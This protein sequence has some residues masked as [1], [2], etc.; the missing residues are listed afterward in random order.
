MAKGICRLCLSPYRS[1]IVKLVNQG[2]VFKRI[3]DKYAPLMNYTFGDR[4][5]YMMTRRH[6]KDQHKEE[7]LIVPQTDNKVSPATIENFAQRM[8][9]LGMQKIEDV[10]PDTIAL[11]DV[12]SAQKLLLDSKKL[13]L[14]ENAMD[15]MLGKL[16]APP[17]LNIIDG[18]LEMD[19]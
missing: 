18:E 9:D 13:R 16:F 3:Y 15:L 19:K 2:V 12:I 6:I 4:G 17:Q 14:S 10:E 7:G 5:F 11:K 1:E 8:L